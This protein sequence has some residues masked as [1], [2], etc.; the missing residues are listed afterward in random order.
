MPSARSFALNLL[1]RRLRSAWEIDQALSRRQVPAEERAEIIQSLTE[2]NL[3]NDFRYGMAWVHTRDR[4][5]PRGA[6]FLEQELRQRG[7]DKA[8]IRLVMAKRAEEIAEEPE[9]NPDEETQIL[10][11]IESKER[12][13]KHLPEEVKKRRLMGFLSRRGFAPERVRRIL[14]L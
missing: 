13:Y 9:L 14:E 4:L 11:L 10:Q 8:T 2:A 5:N 1:K 7:I 12:S 3:I 6:Y